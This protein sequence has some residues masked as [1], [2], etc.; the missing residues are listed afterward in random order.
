MAKVT[1][2]ELQKLEKEKQEMVKKL[3][4]LGEEYDKLKFEIRSIERVLI[5]KHQLYASQKS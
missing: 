5:T 3:Y 2:E 1:F 4:S